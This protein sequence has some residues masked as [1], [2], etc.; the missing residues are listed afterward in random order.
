MNSRPGLL[1]FRPS[2]RRTLSG[3]MTLVAF[4]GSLPGC[5]VLRYKPVALKGYTRAFEPKPRV[6]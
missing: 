4:V 2:L 6:Y 1:D 3:L 5:T